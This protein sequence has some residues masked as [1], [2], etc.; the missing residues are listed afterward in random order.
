MRPSFGTVLWVLLLSAAPMCGQGIIT[1][2]AGSQWVFRGDGGLATDVPLGFTKAVAVDASG[3]IFASDVSNC[4]VAK[5]APSG[6]LRLVAG[7]GICDYSGEGGP[8]T[9]ASLNEPAGVALDAAG[10]LYIAELHRIRKLSATGTITTVAGSSLVGYSGDGGPATRASLYVPNGV[11]VDAAGNLYIA[12]TLNQRIRKV[13]PGGIITTVA[14]NGQEGYSGDGGPATAASLDWPHGVA[15]DAAGNLYIADTRNNR[16]RK[17]TPPGIISTAAGGGSAFPGDGGP[18]TGASLSEPLG[19]AVDSGRNLYIAETFSY[20]IRKVA[21]DGTITTFPGTGQEG[22]SSD[23]GPATGASLGE[24]NGVAVDSA[25]NLYIADTSNYRIVKVTG[26]GVVATV[27]GNGQFRY[28]GDGEPAIAASLNGPSGVSLDSAGNLYIADYRNARIRKVSPAGLITTVAGNGDKKGEPVDGVPATAA[29]LHGPWGVAV[30]PDGNLYIGDSS[31]CLVRMVTPA[32]IITTVAGSWPGYSGDGG[33]ATAASLRGPTGVAMDPAGN[34][35]IAD[36]FNHRIRKVTPAGI[37]TTVAGN[38]Q[39]GYS[40]D[41]GPATAASLYNPEGLALDAAG[42]LYIADTFNLRVRMVSA[43]GTIT[44]VAGDG[45]LRYSGDGGPA[46]SASLMYPGGLALD[47]AGNLYIADASNYRVRKVTA[48]GSITTVAGDG[49]PRYSGDGGPATAASLYAP[50]GVAVDSAGNLYIADAGNN[51]IRAVPVAAPAFS[52]S[53]RTLA[54]SGPSGLAGAASQQVALSSTVA[55]LVW[56]AQAATGSGGNWLAVSPAGGLAPG[57]IA[58]SV[59]ASNLAAGTYRGTVTVQAPQAAPP[60]QTVAVELTVTA[61]PKPQLALEPGSL[62][63]QAQAAGDN[64][65]AQTLRISNA[66][67]GALAW[68]ARAETGSGGQ[69]LGVAQSSGSASAGSPASVQV[70]VTA[71]GLAAGVYSGSIRV[72]SSTTGETVTVPVTLLVAQV[73][74]TILVSQSGLL[75]TGVQGADSAPEQS[76]GILNTGQG[77]MSW[78][79]RSETLSGGAWLR[80]SPASGRS[81]A[82]SL[83]VPQVDVSVSVAGLR[84]GQYSGLIRVE[85]PGANN[86]P[87]YVSVDLTVLPPGSN[88]GV[89]VRP[90]GLIFAA[91][92][93]TSSPGSQTVRLATAAPGSVGTVGGLLTYDGGNWL[94]ALPT[95]LMLSPADPRNIVIQPGLGSLAAGIY[96]AALTLIFGD[97]SPCQAVNVLFLV[98]GAGARA[99][100]TRAEPEADGTCTPGRLHAVHRTLGSSFSAPA[101]WPSPIEVQVMDDCGAAVANATVV[102]SFTNGDPPLALTSLRNGTYIGTWRPVNTAT[103]AVVTVRASLPPL[104]TVEIQARGAVGANAAAPALNSGGIVNGASFAPAAP[105]APGSIISVFGANLAPT[106]AGASTLPLPKTLAGASLQVGG[107]DVP[108]F[109]SSGGQVNAQLPFELALNTR[110]QLIVKGASFVTVPETITVATARPGIFTTTQDGKGQGVIMDVANRLVD[111][112]NPGKAGDVVVVYCTGL[113]ATTP[114]VRSGEAAPASPLARVVTPVTVTIG[115]QPAV[116]QYAGLTPG[117]AGLYQVNVQI[118]AGVSPA[119]SVPLVISQDGVPSNTVSLAVR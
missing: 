99:A 3:N 4:L 79:V 97:G 82:N 49:K 88:P 107:L 61:A 34:L 101:G 45:K 96:R 9:A 93:G 47:A 114:A 112:S 23:S 29:S 81:D 30:S 8:A 80:V 48:A 12:D 54:F 33:P 14:G 51:R 19:V 78:T 77:V 84:A 100:S 70:K 87:Q 92:A 103:Q 56:S 69:W 76:F 27:A 108:L 102:A 53:P 68:T 60:T 72:D 15:A 28:S 22:Y 50:S 71:G 20:R 74:Q 32:G 2:V 89:L 115:G 1:T 106:A 75:F 118:P 36:T 41:G 59:G 21:P 38:G 110:P 17:V 94:Q 90:T 26:G 16:I 24:T 18:A 62:T 6:T 109:Y 13:T 117:Y 85:A 42:N 57:V 119:A 55:G 111:S 66:G 73:T 63:F 40:G 5:I 104:A 52:V 86:S 91:R 95:N 98:V 10:N 67:G 31:A 58:V 116:V 11:A 44:T 7:N 65:A 83:E 25:G 64:P 35:Y 105:L 37:I 46:T 43:T 113:G 39:Q